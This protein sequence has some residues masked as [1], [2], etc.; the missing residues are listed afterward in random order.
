MKDHTHYNERK[1]EESE[2]ITIRRKQWYQK[3]IEK[4]DFIAYAAP[5]EGEKEVSIILEG[6]RQKYPG[7]THYVYAFTLGIKQ[8]MQKFNDDGEPSGTGGM[9]ILEIFR[10]KN[11]CNLMVVVVR[12]F[13]GIKLGTGGLKR[14]YSRTALKAIE[15]AGI[16]NMKLYQ[17]FHLKIDYTYWG[18]I[19]YFLAQLHIPTDKVVFTDMVSLNIPLLPCDEETVLAQVAEIIGDVPEIEKL[20]REYLADLSAD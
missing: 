4:S 18:K 6:V 14:A 8:E 19:E 12:Y 15:E 16:I 13:G 9:P 11:L 2:Y 7:A 17:W 20:D 1:A 10:N 5:I 3:T